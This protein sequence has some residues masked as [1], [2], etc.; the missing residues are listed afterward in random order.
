MLKVL[1]LRWLLPASGLI[2][3]AIMTYNSFQWHHQY[4]KNRR[5]FMWSSIHL[6]AD[7]LN[8]H[9]SDFRSTNCVPDKSGCTE[10]DPETQWIE[11]GLLT[12]ALM[13]S[14]FPVFIVSGILVYLL[15]RVGVSE[16][17]SFMVFMPILSFVWFYMVGCVLARWSLNLTT[18]VRGRL[19]NASPS[20]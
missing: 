11:P 8:R 1:R 2:V 19:P 20:G 13:F 3:F 17:V 7:P 10:W 9:A 6:D 14:A 5:I 4:A 18:W 15:A 12:R 16:A